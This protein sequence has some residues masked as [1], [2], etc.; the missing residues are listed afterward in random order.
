MRNHAAST[1][2]LIRWLP[3]AVVLGGCQTLTFV[4]LPTTSQTAPT[5]PFAVP[6]AFPVRI[7]FSGSADVKKS[8][9]VVMIDPGDAN[10]APVDVTDRFSLAQNAGRWLATGNL[11][12]TPGEKILVAGAC[13]GRVREVTLTGIE[14]K[15]GCKVTRVTVVVAL[16][17][18]SFSPLN[19]AQIDLIAG[20][21][22][23]GS[24]NV[25]LRPPPMFDT[26]VT[27]SSALTDTVTMVFPARGPAPVPIPVLPARASGT[28][29]LTAEGG[30]VYGAATVPLRVMPGLT[31]VTP[32]AAVPGATI[33]IAGAAFTAPMT[34]M[35]GSESAVATILSST[36]ATTQVPALVSQQVQLGVISN[37]QSSPTKLPFTILAP[38]PAAMILYRFAGAEI[39]IFSFT[40][41]ASGG[42]GSFSKLSSFLT[43]SGLATS[44]LVGTDHDNGAL[45]RS[46]NSGVEVYAI[47]GTA[48]APV[49]NF[50]G[51]A[52]AAPSGTATSITFGGGGFVRGTS[53]SVE[54][55]RIQSGPVLNN[56]GVSAS[57]A[58]AGD[59]VLRDSNSLHIFRSTPTTLEI[60]SNNTPPIPADMIHSLLV[61]P[62]AAGSIAG[63]AL[64]A[65]GRVVRSHATG[66]DIFNAAGLPITRVSGNSAGGASLGSVVFAAQANLIARSIAN[67]IEIYS[68]PAS[69][70]PVKC[71]VVQTGDPAVLAAPLKAR[72]TFVFRVT[73][74]SIESYDLSGI[75]CSTTDS[76]QDISVP[77][78]LFRPGPTIGGAGLGLAGPNF[79]A[80]P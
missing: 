20:G 78:S 27:L 47:S 9:Q 79:G 45:V 43:T 17:E 3:L 59:A 26:P 40:P 31:G 44:T 62:A 21:A 33:T 4:D 77:F 18:I 24:V 37:G 19:P 68:N 41:H 29:T 48:A 5:K 1:T 8:F 32:S 14:P 39:Q 75:V 66:I 30:L 69:G 71:G 51:V 49:L 35:F 55:W 38:P 52:N 28:G 73:A 16:P 58:G 63:I 36:S 7:A 6:P 67:G 53:N 60:W 70:D 11:Q 61:N 56:L 46:G 15:P 76:N 80:N 13:W 54:F 2:R 42:G 25:S 65:P 50:R 72:E 12:F 64:L 22:A 23:T 34:V 10:T 74:T 57:L